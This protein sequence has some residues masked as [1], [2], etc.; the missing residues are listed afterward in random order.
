MSF[1]APIRHEYLVLDH[2]TV[3]PTVAKLLPASLMIKYLAVPIAR[4]G[5]CITVAMAHP[6]DDVAVKDISSA[7]GLEVYPVRVNIQ[8]INHLLAE[9]LPG[10]TELSFLLSCQNANNI[11]A[12][13]DYAHYLATVLHAR[14]KTVEKGHDGEGRLLIDKASCHHDLLILGESRHSRLMTNHA[15]R[16]IPLPILLA[17]Q[18]LW[19]IKKILLITRGQ[20]G[21]DDWA[22]DWSIRIA[23]ATNAAVAMLAIVQHLPAFYQRA[24]TQFPE[25]PAGWLNS[26]TPLGNQL[27]RVVQQL[28]IRN[29][30]GILRFR[31]GT[32][33]QQIQRELAS[34]GPD[35]IVIAPDPRTWWQQRLAG[36]LINSMLSWIDRPTLIAKRATGTNGH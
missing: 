15:V 29:I 35:L 10:E 24:A 27:A 2:L 23:Q 11:D 20:A 21:I 30:T 6:N 18:P 32:P 1:V 36:C 13:Q 5:N 31:E 3:N 34:E 17:K 8:T 28:E 9:L 7:L 26:A 19:P 22:V 16:H 12:L 14:L 4:E 33:D 25:G